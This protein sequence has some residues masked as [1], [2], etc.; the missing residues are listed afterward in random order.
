M[1]VAAKRYLKEGQMKCVQDRGE[2]VDLRIE[3]Q[4]ITKVVA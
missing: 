1:H 4:R 3:R 2:H